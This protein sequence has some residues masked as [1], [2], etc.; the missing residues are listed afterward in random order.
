[1]QNNLIDKIKGF[2]KNS[3][4]KV[5]NLKVGTKVAIGIGI[6]TLILA[7][8]F[9]INYSRK[10][11]YKVLFSGLDSVDAANV[12][13]SL[14]DKKVDTKIEGDSILVP[15]DQVDKLR[16]ELS[17]KISNGSKGFELMDKGSNL[18]M[19]DEEFKIEKT[20]LAVSCG[21]TY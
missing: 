8:I 2:S 11:K 6:V 1:M 21:S 15:K 12:T 17:P 18:S 16:I 19:T 13:K 5:K 3:L 9:T 4:E 20:K 10:N 7:L 14:E